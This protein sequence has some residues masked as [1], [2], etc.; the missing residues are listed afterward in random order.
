MVD[1]SIVDGGYKLT[2]NWGVPHCRWVKHDFL[3]ASCQL[4]YLIQPTYT[5]CG[6]DMHNCISAFWGQFTI[7]CTDRC[8][9][10][11]LLMRDPNGWC[12]WVFPEGAIGW[13]HTSI[14]SD[15][16]PV[17]PNYMLYVS[18]HTHFTSSN[19][20]HLYTLNFLNHSQ[21]QQLC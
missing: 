15:V 10:T 2:Y 16:L 14:S 7:N 9:G 13:N 12:G 3:N 19:C 1:I 4:Q 5:D 8:C 17:S 6:Y 11:K 18:L 20:I 21:T